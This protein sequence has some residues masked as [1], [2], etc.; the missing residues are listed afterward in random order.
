VL[1]NDPITDV[2]TVTY[3]MPNIRKGQAH[4]LLKINEKEN[5]WEKL[6]V[7]NGKRSCAHDG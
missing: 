4:F 7:N 1:C 2:K 5:K 6:N 3:S